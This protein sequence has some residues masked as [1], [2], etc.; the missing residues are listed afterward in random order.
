MLSGDFFYINSVHQEGEKLT[1]LLSINAGHQIFA[2][3]FPGQPVVPGVCMM[4]MIQEILETVLNKKI[5]LAGA[6]NLK[7]LALIDP[8]ETNLIN[9]EIKYSLTDDG[10]VKVTAALVNETVTYFKMNGLYTFLQGE[11]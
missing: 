7:F 4:Q 5:T 6:E 1:A 10:K 8:S 3:H 9:A 2:G 11:L